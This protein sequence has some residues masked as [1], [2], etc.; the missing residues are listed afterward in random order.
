MRLNEEIGVLYDVTCLGDTYFNR[1][2]IE[3]SYQEKGMSIDLR[4]RPF[5]E[6]MEKVG[7]LPSFLS[8]FFCVGETGEPIIAKFFDNMVD[9]PSVSIEL[10]LSNFDDEEKV[11]GAVVASFFPYLDEK[12]KR[13][14]V[15]GDISLWYRICGESDLPAE[16]Q[17]AMLYMVS[18]YET[19]HLEIRRE[20]F[21]IYTIIKA[22]H[23]A[24]KEE[25]ERI[26]KAMESPEEMKQLCDQHQIDLTGVEE[27]NIDL[28]V[29]LMNPIM[30]MGTRF[31]NVVIFVC[32]GEYLLL[33]EKKDEFL[34]VALSDFVVNCGTKQ[35]M[36]ILLL[37]REHGVLTAAQLARVLEVSPPMAW[38]YVEMLYK[39]NILMVNKKEAKNIYY[40]L[41]PEYF[42]GVL[43]SMEE[44]IKGI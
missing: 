40:S 5:R 31:Q 23:L 24:H 6:V 8:L 32:G 19:L 9:V 44:F 43:H 16:M 25:I 35:K 21:R 41:N 18:S 17:T 4:F 33:T 12:S 39:H 22:Y 20:L 37:F 1:E 7:V 2:R 11:L 14:L 28:G 42:R 29:T 3:R 15:A 38:R 34:D 10:F 30:S 36:D 26:Y 27:N 13:K